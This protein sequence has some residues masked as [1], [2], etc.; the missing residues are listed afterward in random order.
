MKH[1]PKRR[2]CLARGNAL[3]KLSKNYQ[4]KEDY[5]LLRTEEPPS[6]SDY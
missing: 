2:C 1:Q 3:D 5:N 6:N 4:E